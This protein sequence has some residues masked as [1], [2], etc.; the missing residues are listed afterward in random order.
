MMMRDINAYIDVNLI[1]F[2]AQLGSDGKELD[3]DDLPDPEVKDFL[4]YL[5]SKDTTIRD[6][7]RHHMQCLIN[8]RLDE[9]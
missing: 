9:V 3:L 4:D 8:K 7:V 5:M 2:Y 1:G 6:V